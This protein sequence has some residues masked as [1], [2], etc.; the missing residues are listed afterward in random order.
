MRPLLLLLLL[1]LTSA[2][3]TTTCQGLCSDFLANDL[4]DDSCR[5]ALQLDPRPTTYNACKK[6]RE[7]G[8]RDSCI[9]TCIPIL[10]SR[11]E[12]E[13]GGAVIAAEPQPKPNSFAACDGSKN[14]KRRPNNPFARCRQAYEVAFEETQKGI[15]ERARAAVTAVEGEGKAVAAEE[16]P[17]TASEEAPI[18]AS[19]E[20]PTTED[21]ALH[22]FEEPEEDRPTPYLAPLDDA[23]IEEASE[24]KGDR[25]EDDGATVI[26]IES[27]DNMATES[28]TLELEPLTSKEIVN[29]PN[30]SGPVGVE[31]LHQP[32]GAN[33]PTGPTSLV[34][35]SD[36]V[37]DED[38]DD[39]SDEVVDTSPP[40]N[41]VSVDSEI[42]PIVDV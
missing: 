23:T 13:D 4:S 11:E 21:V 33:G 16:A 7:R 30:D 6:G 41:H 3:A 9:P 40:R 37:N 10:G 36:D 18:T 28:A 35:L 5:G 32:G 22:K 12:G 8:H 19:E 27:A 34:P 2:A 38:I 17:I 26:E 1:A 39:V 15:A 24:P 20:A 31:E 14:K 42:T 25:A 29:E